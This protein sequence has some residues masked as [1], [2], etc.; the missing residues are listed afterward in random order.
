MTEN[1]IPSN[2]G[3]RL[4]IDVF[5]W[6]GNRHDSAT[7]SIQQA[8]HN[9]NPDGSQSGGLYDPYR[10]MPD[11]SQPWQDF[12]IYGVKV[13]PES[14]SWYIDGVQTNQITTPTV[15]LNSRLYMM[16]DYALGGGW[17]LDGMVNNSHMDVDWVRV[18]SLPQQDDLSVTV[19][20]SS[21]ALGSAAAY[22]T[23]DGQGGLPTSATAGSGG[24]SV[25]LTGNVWKRWGLDY[26]YTADTR[27]EFTVNGSDVGE[28]IGVALDNNTD[29]I[30]GRRAFRVGGSDVNTTSHDSWSWK[31]TP[32]YTAGSGS[33]T[34]AINVGSYFTGAV[35]YLG[36]FGDDD[37]NG[38]TNVTFSN[39]KLYEAGSTSLTVTLG[40]TPT[41][42]GA[43]AAYDSSQ[44]GQGGLPTSATTVLS[45]AGVTLAGNV[46]KRWGMNYTVTADTVLE[47]TVNASDAGEIVGI[48]LDTDTNP[49]YGRRAFRFGGSDVDQTIFNSWSW[50]VTPT[51]T[52]GSGDRTYTI[53]IGDY[54]TGT[55]NYLGLF[56]DDDANGSANATFKNIR[57][58][59]AGAAPLV[60]GAPS[61]YGT[62]DGQG[63]LPTSAT[64][65]P[66]GTAATLAGNA[67]KRWNFNYTVTTSTVLEFTVNASDAGEIIGIALDN[68]ADP[69]NGRRAFRI[70]GSDVGYGGNDSWSW[71]ITPTYV[72]GGG[73]VT[74]TINVG[75][76]F[77]GTVNYLGLFADDDANGSSLITFSNIRIYE[78]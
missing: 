28:I 24:S 9:W 3:Y 75:Q 12:H 41:S 66:D 37:A 40:S 55:V 30:Y 25:T 8:S 29:P 42:L 35:S 21:T 50:Q 13:T 36:L 57:L 10:L 53:D 34:Y 43:P 4:E 56:G 22:G 38:S 20:G 52:A 2:E 19:N 23:Q 49:L 48:A 73:Q 59:E 62:Q 69:L 60:L 7:G 78:S 15:Y 64:I 11:G 67:W 18:Y 17:P 63:G 72:A 71:N 26:N 70:G 6:Y 76:Y 45:G 39:I 16:V 51:Y 61:A 31:M 77:T 14:I 46:W 5:E 44:D 1:S 65:S 27:L 68:D 58:Y 33:Q 74:Y 47:F 54:F 32:V